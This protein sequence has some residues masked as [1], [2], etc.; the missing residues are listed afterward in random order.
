MAPTAFSPSAAMSCRAAPMRGDLRTFASNWASVPLGPAGGLAH[1]LRGD[2]AERRD[3]GRYRGP[4]GQ[5]AVPG[6]GHGGRGG[7][8]G[9]IERHCPQPGSSASSAHR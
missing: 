1:G 9:R 2:A 6:A 3:P 5:H 8:R 4:V 7:M